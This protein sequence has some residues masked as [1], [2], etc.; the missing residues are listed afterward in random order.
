MM[1]AVAGGGCA[2]PST[3]GTSVLARGVSYDTSN[4]MLLRTEHPGPEAYARLFELVLDVIDDD[5]EIAV[6]SR[7]DGRIETLPRI[8]PGIEQ[9]FKPGS[10]SLYDRL[11][12][13]CQT[14]RHRC[15]VIIQPAEGG[16]LVNV[17]V[18]KELEDLPNPTREQSGAAAFRTDQ[19]ID[20]EHEI[21]DP[22][23]ISNVWIPKG[24][25]IPLEQKILHNIRWKV[26]D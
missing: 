14:Y 6:A 15:F 5:F 24:R 26:R 17:T 4:E 16:Y 18:V 22:L 3:R 23:V 7:Y 19:N 21:V 2:M 8:A 13:T 9:P 1:L 20:R 10:P 11:L 12:Y 25:D